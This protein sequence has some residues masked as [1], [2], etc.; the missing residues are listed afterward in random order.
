[1]EQTS[2]QEYVAKATA[3]EAQE[4]L[5]I[6]YQRLSHLRDE[7][8]RHGHTDLDTETLHA[9]QEAYLISNHLGWLIS[10]S[11]NLERSTRRYRNSILKN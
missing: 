6:E 9:L 8:I 4:K 11:D 3:E 2:T 1:L 10:I 5:K 7:D